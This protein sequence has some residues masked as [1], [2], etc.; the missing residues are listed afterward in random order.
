[1][2]LLTERYAVQIAAVVSCY[3]AFA[4]ALQTLRRGLRIP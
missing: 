3:A 4:G 2:T 1:M